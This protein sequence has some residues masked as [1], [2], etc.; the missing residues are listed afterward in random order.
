MPTRC[1]VVLYGDSLVLAGVGRS[2]ERYPRFE[3]LSL[4]ASSADAP[5]ELDALRPAAV[6]LDLSVVTTELAFSLLDE[7]PDLLL[8]GLDPGGNGLLVL[9][10]QHARQLTAADLAQL[11]D[12]SLPGGQGTGTIEPAYRPLLQ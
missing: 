8:I 6:I 10:G 2:L 9:S 11:I 5:R 7:R 12:R 3:V 1:K 4:D